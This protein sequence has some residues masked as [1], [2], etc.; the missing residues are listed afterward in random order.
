MTRRPAKAILLF[1][2]I[3]VYSNCYGLTIEQLTRQPLVTDVKIAPDGMTL[4]L[5][6]FHEDRH[7]LRF[8]DRKTLEVVGGIDLPSKTEVGNYHWV[9]NERVVGELYRFRGQNA[10]KFYGELFATNVDGSQTKL[11]FGFRSGDIRKNS[12]I[13]K[14]VADRAWGRV[15]DVLPD[16]PNHI[17]ISSTQMSRSAGKRA[18]A[19]LLDVYS[20]AQKSLPALSRYGMGKFYT[21]AAGNVR[22]IVS[23][24]DD[25]KTH[26]QALPPGTE[27]WLDLPDTVHG[28]YFNPVAI[29]QDNQYVYVLDDADG[30]KIGLYKLALDGEEYSLEYEHER[31]DITN[32]KKSADERSIY[33]VRVDDGYPRYLLFADTHDEATLFKDMLS[34]F[35]GSIVG[36]S[37]RSQDGKLWIVR[38]GS[39][40][41]AGSFYLFDQEQMKLI[42]LFASRPEVDPDALSK[43]EPIRFESFD[44]QSIDGYFTPAKGEYSDKVPPLVVLVHGGPAA[45]DYWGYRST[46]QVLATNGYSVLQIN[47]RGSTGYGKAFEELGNREWG[48]NVQKDIIAGTRWAVNEGRGEAGRICIMGGSFGAYSAVQSSILAPDLYSCAVA[49]AGIYDLKLLY[50]DGDIETLYFG[51]A[52]LEETIGRDDE[53]LEAYSPVNHVA[54]LKTPILIAHGKQDER[55]PF[56]HARLLRRALEQHNKEYEWFVKK[57]EAHGFYDNENRVEYLKTA[58]KFLGEKLKD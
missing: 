29:S 21:D 43:M 1:G 57:R 6:I 32:V 25:G 28:D 10:P 13:R 18:R 26:L 33:G 31:V 23:H 42:H 12:R 52:F 34:T 15:V 49:N 17:L 36:I 50:T 48:D 39:D 56:K 41:D 55:A 37:S 51:D 24:N 2:L 16:D 54:S 9:N 46:V 7:T 3:L 45:R 14:S 8:L 53:E 22:L 38:T 47:Y 44:G 30:D 27:E 58:L 5:R 20:G 11:I 19:E 4:A 35:A 40:R